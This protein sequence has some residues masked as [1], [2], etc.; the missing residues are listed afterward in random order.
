MR[1]QSLFA[2][3]VWMK[4]RD[5]KKVRRV[6][7]CPTSNLFLKSGVMHWSAARKSGVTLSLGSDVGAGPDLSIYRVMRCAWEVHAM[8]AGRGPGP[9]D[10][11]RAATLGGAEALGFDDLGSL[12]PGKCADFQVLDWNQIVPAG[13]PPAESAHDLVS[14]IVHRGGRSAV[15]Q[16]F[17][18]GR[19]S[20]DRSRG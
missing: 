8:R 11:L 20:V 9:E 18:A 15:R 2:H 17:V 16:V 13:A 3:C 19:M 12:E 1:P 4:A 14:R 6:S 7:H 10:L 5:W